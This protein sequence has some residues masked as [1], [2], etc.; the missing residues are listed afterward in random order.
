MG[1]GAQYSE[2]LFQRQPPSYSYQN[3]SCNAGKACSALRGVQ[4]ARRRSPFAKQQNIEK[5]MWKDTGPELRA[6]KATTC[7]LHYVPAWLC[8]HLYDHSILVEIT[9]RNF[10]NNCTVMSMGWKHCATP[11]KTSRS[12]LL[13]KRATAPAAKGRQLFPA[14]TLIWASEKNSCLLVWTMVAWALG[15]EVFFAR[16]L[17][18]DSVTKTQMNNKCH[19]LK[20]FSSY[21]S[22][23]N[24]LSSLFKLQW[25]Q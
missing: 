16:L 15:R 2:L 3:K 12:P 23:S 7:I 17:I 1:K 10:T 8:L 4:T 5:Y 25:V 19:F 18:L 20:L 13:A 6:E 14:A 11:A 22:L 9:S 21:P 24:N